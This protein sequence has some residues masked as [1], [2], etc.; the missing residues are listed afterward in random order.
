M[1]QPTALMSDASRGQGEGLPSQGVGTQNGQRS[2]AQQIEVGRSIA[3][4]SLE[5]SPKTRVQL[6]ERLR[7]GGVDGDVCDEVFDRL[8]AVGLI[9]DVAFAMEW[10]RSRHAVRGLARR[11]LRQ[12]LTVK[13]VAAHIIDDA[14]EQITAD[15]EVAAARRMADRLRQKMVPL[16]D[17][18][19]VR[20]VAGRLARRGYSSDIVRA[21]LQ[22]P[23]D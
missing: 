4:R 16:D 6:A 5:G 11:A 22:A 3:L 10:V 20:R 7:R 23:P 8:E 13:G 14:L 19:V 18:A 2:R 15:D 21:A 17:A 1:R 12:E 9:D